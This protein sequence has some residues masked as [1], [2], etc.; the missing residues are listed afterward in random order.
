MGGTL[1]PKVNSSSSVISQLKAKAKRS[2]DKDLLKK[3]RNTK[4]RT[5]SSKD[6]ADKEKDEKPRKMKAKRPSKIVHVVKSSPATEKEEVLA[7]S[8]HKKPAS[9]DDDEELQLQKEL[10]DLDCTNKSLF[11]VFQE[12]GALIADNIISDFR[13]LGGEFLHGMKG[14]GAAGEH[15]TSVLRGGRL[16]DIAEGKMLA[17]GAARGTGSSA[18]EDGREPNATKIAQGSK[19]GG[20]AAG[21]ALLPSGA[22]CPTSF[23]K[24]TSLPSGILDA[25]RSFPTT[26]T[27]PDVFPSLILPVQGEVFNLCFSEDDTLLALLTLSSVLVYETAPHWRL[28]GE[29]SLFPA[30]QSCS[31]SA[32]SGSLT[33]EQ[34]TG[35]QM[36][37]SNPLTHLPCISRAV[38]TA[39]AIHNGA[40]AS[41]AL[42]FDNLA[43]KIKS[44]PEELTLEQDAIRRNL[45]MQTGK[46]PVVGTLAISRTTTTSS[47]IEGSS[48][49][50]GSGN[51][52]DVSRLLIAV[53][54]RH[55]YCRTGLR[56]VT[57]VYRSL[58]PTSE[59]GGVMKFEVLHSIPG[60]DGLCFSPPRDGGLCLAMSD[61]F[62]GTNA[63]Y[64]MDQRLF[65]G[66][67][68]SV[69][70]IH[71]A[72]EPGAAT[73]IGCGSGG[74]N[75]PPSSRA[76]PVLPVVA[77]GASGEGGA[78][79]S[80]ALER[81]KLYQMGGRIRFKYVGI[82]SE[83]CGE[84]TSSS[85][86]STSDRASGAT[87]AA[88]L[89]LTFSQDGT[90]RIACTRFIHA[91]D[92]SS[93]HPQHLRRL[94]ALSPRSEFA[95]HA[96]AH[97]VGGSNIFAFSLV[98]D[99]RIYLMDT[100]TYTILTHVDE[101][102]ESTALTTNPS[103]LS[104]TRSLNFEFACGARFLAKSCADGRMGVWDAR[105]NTL[106][107][108]VQDLQPGA[109]VSCSS[110]G[111]WICAPMAG[112]GGVKVFDVGFRD[113][114]AVKSEGEG[115]Y[116]KCALL[117]RTGSVDSCLGGAETNAEEVGEMNKKISPVTTT[118]AS[119][120]A[121]AHD[122][123]NWADQQK[124][125]SS[126]DHQKTSC[127]SP[128]PTPLPTVIAEPQEDDLMCVNLRDPA[129]RLESG[130][131][132]SKDGTHLA[133]GYDDCVKIY[134]VTTWELLATA[135]L[136]PV[137]FSDEFHLVPG[138]CCTPDEEEEKENA[139]FARSG[140]GGVPAPPIRSPAC[141][142][143]TAGSLDHLAS[144]AASRAGSRRIARGQHSGRTRT[145]PR[146][147]N[148]SSLRGLQGG[149]ASIG[150]FGSRQTSGE[151][152]AAMNDVV[153]NVDA[154]PCEFGVDTKEVNFATDCSGAVSPSQAEL[155]LVPFDLDD[156]EP[157]HWSQSGADG[158][159][160]EDP[161]SSDREEDRINRERESDY[162]RSSE[163]SDDEDYILERHNQDFY[164][165]D[166]S[167]DGL[168]AVA[169][170]ILDYDLR[171]TCVGKKIV[172]Y[173]AL[174]AHVATEEDEITPTEDEANF[175]NRN[176]K[177]TRPLGELL[178]DNSWKIEKQILCT[179]DHV[180]RYW[181]LQGSFSCSTKRS[182][183]L[184]AAAV[185][186]YSI[187]VYSCSDWEVVHV[188]DR[189][190]NIC[191][192]MFS[193]DDRWFCV[194]EKLFQIT[195]L[196]KKQ[197]LLA[198]STDRNTTRMSTGE[199]GGGGAGV[200]GEINAAGSGLGSVL[201]VGAGEGSTPLSPRMSREEQKLL[202]R[203]ATTVTAS[204]AGKNAALGSATAPTPTAATMESAKRISASS[205]PT[206]ENIDETIRDLPHLNLNL[207]AVATS[208]YR[209][210][211]NSAR[212]PRLSR[213]ETLFPVPE[214]SAA[215]DEL[216]RTESR[217]EI[218]DGHDEP[219]LAPLFSPAKI[220][221]ATSLKKSRNCLLTFRPAFRGKDSSTSGG[222]STD[223]GGGSAAFSASCE[224]AG[225]AGTPDA[226]APLF[227]I[228]LCF[229][230]DSGCLLTYNFPED[231]VCILRLDS[232][233]GAAVDG[234]G[235][236]NGN[237]DRRTVAIKEESTNEGGGG[238][239]V[240][241]TRPAHAQGQGSRIDIPG[242]SVTASEGGTTDQQ[243]AAS[244]PQPQWILERKLNVCSGTGNSFAS[245][246]L[247]IGAFS[248]SP[249]NS[250]W[251][252]SSVGRFTRFWDLSGAKI[253]AVDYTNHA[254]QTGQKM[255]QSQSS[256]SLKPS[257]SSLGGGLNTAF[258]AAATFGRGGAG[259]NAKEQVDRAGAAQNTTNSTTTKGGFAAVAQKALTVNHAVDNFTKNSTRAG[260]G[261]TT[262]AAYAA[263]SQSF[264]GNY[265]GAALSSVA[266]ASSFQV[267]PPS[268]NRER[269][270]TPHKNL[271]GSSH[272]VGTGAAGSSHFSGLG[273]N[274]ISSN[275]GMQLAFLLQTDS[276]GQ[277]MPALN[278][279]TKSYYFADGNGRIYNG[280]TLP[281]L[282]CPG[283]PAQSGELLN[284]QLISLSE[285]EH[286]IQR[287]TRAF[288]G[289]FNLRDWK[290]E[291]SVLHYV[292]TNREVLKL[293]FDTKKELS[294]HE[295]DKSAQAQA[296][297]AATSANGSNGYSGGGANAISNAAPKTSLAMVIRMQER[298]VLEMFAR[299]ILAGY[300]S[301]KSLLH[302]WKVLPDLLHWMPVTTERLLDAFLV[303]APFLEPAASRTTDGT[304]TKSSSQ[305][306]L[307]ADLESTDD[308]MLT[309]GSASNGYL[310]DKKD[311]WGFLT[312]IVSGKQ[313]KLGPVEP[314][315]VALPELIP[316]ESG[317]LNVL[318]DNNVPSSFFLKPVVRVLIDYK[319][320]VF[321]RDELF[322]H[323][324]TYFVFLLAYTLFC[325]QLRMH[326]ASP[327]LVERWFLGEES[328]E[329]ALWVAFA[330]VAFTV[331]MNYREV[332]DF[333]PPVL[334]K[335]APSAPLDD[336]NGMGL[337]QPQ[338]LTTIES[339][340]NSSPA[341]E[342]DEGTE[343]KKLGADLPQG[344]PASVPGGS[345][346]SI[347]YQ[348]QHPEAATGPRGL[349]TSSV[350]GWSRHYLSMQKKLD[351]VRK[352]YHTIVQK[353]RQNRTL[354][355]H[356]S[357]TW[358]WSSSVSFSGM[359]LRS[360]L[361]PT[362]LRRYGWAIALS[363]VAVFLCAQVISDP[364]VNA[365]VVM[366][367]LLY[368][369]RAV[370]N[371]IVE[372]R[373]KTLEN[374]L[375]SV[376]NVFDLTLCVLTMTLIFLY[377][378]E[379]SRHSS[380]LAVTVDDD[381]NKSIRNDESTVTTWASLA[382][383]LV[384]HK[385]LY[386]FLPFRNVGS[387]IR[388]IIEIF[389]DIR[390]FLLVCFVTL[391]GFG[392]A[393]FVLYK[394]DWT[395]AL[396]N[397]D[398]ARRRSLASS[399]M[400]DSDY[401]QLDD[402][403]AVP[404]FPS[405]FQTLLSMY[406]LMLGDWEL[407]AFTH[408][409]HFLLSPVLFVIFTFMMMVVLFNMLIA[410]MSETYARVR[411]NEEA[412][413][414]KTRAECIVDMEKLRWRPVFYPEWVHALLP[415]AGG[416]QKGG[417]SEKNAYALNTIMGSGSSSGSSST[418]ARL[419]LNN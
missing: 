350:A 275:E 356:F 395:D 67:P 126:H 90:Q 302:V 186:V 329:V 133:L 43:N 45:L 156:G 370:L 331:I 89:P 301:R 148:T 279:R 154:V 406:V 365:I 403:E 286:L 216:M 81:S 162:D 262:N 184:F 290:T 328:L 220:S 294:L 228:G 264:R 108:L 1:P 234:A 261:D 399:Y 85:T 72:R 384:W 259:Q 388:M 208:F 210:V 348:K 322:F 116:G 10:D 5:T 106:S 289:W 34:A 316:A 218:G 24:A 271:P 227:S 9:L 70:N 38:S 164:L 338:A 191:R 124:V 117:Q 46:L 21:G 132:F 41:R 97:A 197:L 32:S 317:L 146:S 168:L 109:A 416:E 78:P 17:S 2:K 396:A 194:E 224:S 336:A 3:A 30:A 355:K 175:Y 239:S 339:S 123:V 265:P 141:V 149:G 170:G 131:V 102:K 303:P 195:W 163:S 57:K 309:Q 360:R 404:H 231:K 347:F 93:R 326:C 172:I 226:G 306:Q 417:R 121:T 14:E 314:Y 40:S 318:V 410:L 63:I 200:V 414:L 33:A 266:S 257:G 134:S 209:D 68:I 243:A 201:P 179:D 202:R 387:F 125:S 324:R 409:K 298:D 94:Y 292:I 160:D 401:V 248:I 65:V 86:S 379:Q 282:Y 345:S 205:L 92:T 238:P 153:H 253:S 337:P 91:L 111:A 167:A 333:K 59:T 380:V 281:F 330:A 250:R 196:D 62:A 343:L 152:V 110:N 319:W 320:K 327:S 374:Y 382:I 284:E 389:S 95:F 138:T 28:V 183:L 53:A 44:D 8:S 177:C 142:I 315:I 61:K 405:V 12:T 344:S 375:F 127:S 31:T 52:G 11:K 349:T 392:S 335:K 400:Q 219:E 82:H 407:S 308:N 288:P 211:L 411:E 103:G 151:G 258:S 361:L 189:T 37:R 252:A 130:N 221:L 178:D 241:P 408:S 272:L 26:R 23:W 304:T 390:Y 283:T 385:C 378:F 51:V 155:K 84:G 206:D 372:A 240:L 323:F 147:I 246:A 377:L 165:L 280:Q 305:H 80:K 311:F 185:A 268:M 398:P 269:F 88:T 325:M 415:A 188:V 122:F 237:K 20:G 273:G 66:T 222:A 176:T 247:G 244:P 346:A 366:V 64:R 300:F 296:A 397:P 180:A 233:I 73:G 79:G 386:F 207:T 54:V 190:D 291:R 150:G 7:L 119:S 376:W 254:L 263:A 363:L 135:V 161:P 232:S 340:R 36:L 74:L 351:L 215:G 203:A 278:P 25:S 29:I 13:F 287:W 369:L 381:G 312:D 158:D 236:A 223:G 115:G 171:K 413:F 76:S 391:G 48:N 260:A 173:R 15:G 56:S 16:R 87:K 270:K 204:L 104:V 100:L 373:S 120:L 71:S 60:G 159:S 341:D 174:E 419:I 245:E 217:S 274:S 105:T 359:H 297:V 6:P 225:P 364:A 199:G 293:I 101:T 358:V 18:E 393:F 27:V 313:M 255:P 310:V 166:F 77:A 112:A 96:W 371:E 249:F 136:A 256:N 49:L 181:C 144:C 277:F 307:K 55:P 299:H 129:R 193:T 140:V 198:S 235:D 367:M 137:P 383:L 213:Q 19:C 83:I 285:K 402:P 357:S 157:P 145:P 114:R 332:P 143:P 353:R 276:C 242:G 229:S 394:E 295:S 35:S 412:E 368:T 99:L 98:G 47:S 187:T 362:W 342:D 75:S 354:S 418:P 107:Y 4:K 212:I 230:H 42:M 139:C 182:K 352:N 58:R 69:W 113:R 118:T 192:P 321:A 128:N 22:Q 334:M 50:T 267:V 169:H 214:E 251:L 39:S